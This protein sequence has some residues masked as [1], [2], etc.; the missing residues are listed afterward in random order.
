MRVQVNGFPMYV[1][2]RGQGPVITF[3][4]GFP[5]N[6]RIFD[7]QVR[8]LSR[9]FRVLAPDLRGFGKTPFAGDDIRMDTYADDIAALLDALDVEQT[10]LA[11][12]SMGG[13][14]A[15]AFWRRYPE[16]VRGLV[17]LNTRASADTDEARQNRFRTIEA[18]RQNGL[19]PLI[20]GM[21]PKLLSPVTQR[22]KPHVVRK[23]EDIMRSA[24]VEGVIA[25]L[26]AMAARP[27]SRPTLNTIHVPT[28]ILTGRDDALIPV[29]EAEEMALAIP[30]A[31][32]HVIDQA[33]HLVTME[34]PRTTSRL[35]EA[36][37]QSVA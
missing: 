29:S 21:V 19:D 5:L 6:H 7:T 30:D 31:R 2:A 33:G 35:L 26:Q 8:T 23:V 3:V 25:A 10:V 28:L 34:R 15:F 4:H 9:H 24:T 18:I 32:L 14:I 17:L 16:R 11:G 12:L 22:G 1:A 36:F 37:L 13:Y 20:Q 27:D